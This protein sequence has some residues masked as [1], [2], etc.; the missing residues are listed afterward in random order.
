[1]NLRNVRRLAE[2]VGLAGVDIMKLKALVD[3]ADTEALQ[4]SELLVQAYKNG[5]DGDEVNYD[6][7]DIAYRAALQAVRK[8]RG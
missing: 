8:R 1:M 5:E 4:A 7:V 2:K 3:S 6:D